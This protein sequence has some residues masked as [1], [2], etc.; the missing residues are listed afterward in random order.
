MRALLVASMLLAIC[1]AA[2]TADAHACVSDACGPC[3]EDDHRHL[4]QNGTLRCESAR[5]DRDAPA[6]PAVLL[7]AALGAAGLV[8]ARSR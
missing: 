6:L 1:L 2:G 7:L 3:L 5:M 8:R 4:W